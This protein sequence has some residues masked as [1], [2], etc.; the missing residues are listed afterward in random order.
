[1]LFDGH[2]PRHLD[3]SCI[4]ECVT[5]LD[6]QGVLPI[7]D[8]KALILSAFACTP[9]PRISGMYSSGGGAGGGAVGIS[10]GAIAIGIPSSGRE[11]T[12]GPDIPECTSTSNSTSPL[13][14]RSFHVG[15]ICSPQGFLRTG[16]H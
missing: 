13:E 15:S 14:L 9:C 2:L 16:L 6:S 10:L 3:T 1:M 4:H 5:S 7:S 8:Q 11:V 12:G